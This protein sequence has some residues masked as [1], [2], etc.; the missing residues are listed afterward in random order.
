M[1][2]SFNPYVEWLGLDPSITRP[3]H[4]QLF[5]LEEC[6][7]DQEKI[8]Q[9]ADRAMSKVRGFRPGEHA[10]AWA[11][12]LDELKQ[13]KSCLTESVLKDLYDQQLN[14]DPEPSLEQ[15][16]QQPITSDIETVTSDLD[17]VSMYPPSPSETPPVSPNTAVTS[18]ASPVTPPSET[19]SPAMPRGASPGDPATVPNPTDLPPA[20]PPPGVPMAAAPTAG[21]PMAN[22]AVPVA[23]PAQQPTAPMQANQT[24]PMA[25]NPMAPQAIPTPGG[26]PN[27]TAPLNPPM[28]SPQTDMAGGPMAPLAGA[29][30]AMGYPQQVPEAMPASP[31]APL[32]GTMPE[33]ANPQ[34]PYNLAPVAGFP[35][36]PQP[37]I[38][39]NPMMPMG[40]APGMPVNDLAT[41]NPMAATNPMTTAA[42]PVAGF[43]DPSL[44]G[45]PEVGT[46]KSTTQRASEQA[47]SGKQTAVTLGVGACLIA[48]LFGI[49]FYT[50]KDGGHENNKQNTNGLAK[51]RRQDSNGNPRTTPR[52]PVVRDKPSPKPVPVPTPQPNPTP[53]PTPLPEPGPK[54]I[55]VP[56]PPP[57]PDPE[58][59][60]KP[61][62]T[63]TREEL[64]VLGKSLSAARLALAERKLEEADVQLA[65]AESL[66]KL[67]QHKQMV[68]RTK[69]LA[70]NVRKFWDAVAIGLDK[71]GSGDELKV[72]ASTFVAIV[73]ANPQ[74]LVIR[75]GGKNRRYA[76]R[77]IPG[78]LAIV[79]VDRGLDLTTAE[80][81]VIKGAI[82]AADKDPE[83]RAKAKPYW[84]E[85]AAGLDLG[86]LMEVLDDSYDLEK[87]FVES[88]DSGNSN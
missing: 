21:I 46:E 53:E 20:V 22:P 60:P 40:G 83:N 39:N 1:Q 34:S 31:Q 74:S 87:D 51:N 61:V 42:A 18:P 64:L 62:P 82:Y 36:S 88:P 32:Q 4:Y 77:D 9:A 49:I 65:M 70:G 2:E 25:N 7:S 48:I 23:Y 38:A 50:M 24:L 27:Q 14:S 45:V 47:G 43:G 11:M 86:D 66:A 41:S 13:A 58:P 75:A 85:A 10:Q 3:N 57:K 63:P 33:T 59:A 35:T 29:P 12:L 5:C 15:F 26:Y 8:S 69:R 28:P 67:P 81:R 80:S 54:P 6:E 19:L 76:T 55:P 78:G 84:V 71:L 52:K 16:N 30:T 68:A 56:E 17:T 73:E 44:P 79:I 37:P 72:D